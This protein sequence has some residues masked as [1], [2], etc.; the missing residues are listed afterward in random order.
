MMSK[1]KIH[2]VCRANI[3]RSRLAEGYFKKLTGDKYEVSSS[4]VERWRHP[5]KYKDKWANSLADEHHFK[6]SPKS[7]Q[8]TSALLAEQ[9]I[10]IF[11]RKD[12]Y[13]MARK[14]MKFDKKKVIIW[15]IRDRRDYPL[16]T[17]RVIRRFETWKA[18][19]ISVRKLVQALDRA[20]AIK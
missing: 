17:K 1:L 2:F 11:V 13:D 16:L 20:K 8:T 14:T 3:Y 12:V 6:L 4:G 10:I 15:D 9:D 19:D 7:V 18:I 5:F